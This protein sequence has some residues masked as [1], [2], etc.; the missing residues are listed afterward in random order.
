[1]TIHPDTLRA[2]GELAKGVGSLLWPVSFF[3][4]M[5]VFK[6]QVIKLLERIKSGKLFGAEFDASLVR[7]IQQIEDAQQIEEGVSIGLLP[8]QSGESENKPLQKAQSSAAVEQKVTPA[9]WTSARPEKY[10]VAYDILT[11]ELANT[12]SN[13]PEVTIV[14]LCIV[15]EERLRHLLSL[16]NVIVP[17]P[18][19]SKW[20]R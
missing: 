12:V 14:L 18:R 3:C 2:F 20:S 17:S 19:T 7:N 4:L 9:D 1:M 5:L 8:S 10:S 13:A 16:E 6:P 11:R 15:L